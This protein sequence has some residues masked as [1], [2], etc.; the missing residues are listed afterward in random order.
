MNLYEQKQRQEFF[1]LI[2]NYAFF[3]EDGRLILEPFCVL[4]SH[5]FGFDEILE[6][7]PQ[8]RDVYL[9]LGK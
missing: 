8:P 4:L 9:L 5:C 7:S 3:R 6:I 1:D 2:S